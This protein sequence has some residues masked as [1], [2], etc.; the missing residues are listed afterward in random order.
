MR[1]SAFTA[2]QMKSIDMSFETYLK[3]LGLNTDMREK[4]DKESKEAIRSKATK[5]ADAINK[6]MQ[7][8]NFKKRPM[9][10]IYA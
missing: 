5:T 3:K 6:A 8:G 4:L 2:W 1:A 9:V 10:N 7:Q